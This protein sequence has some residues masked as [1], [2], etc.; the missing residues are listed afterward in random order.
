MKT[1]LITT[2]INIPHVLKLYRACSTDVAFFVTGDMKTDS[3]PFKQF[4]REI[5]NCFAYDAVDQNTSMNWACHE[6]IGWNTIGRRNIA[7]LEA[8]KWGADIIVTID[9]DNIPMNLD[10]F[11]DFE[12][13]LQAPFSG[14]QVEPAVWFNVGA[15]CVPNFVQR[16]FPVEQ[17]SNCYAVKHVVNAKI[18]VASGVALLDPDIGAVE[19]IA[20][21]PNIHGVYELLRAGVAFRPQWKQWTVF[22]SQVT[23]FLR[24]LAPAMLM[25]PQWKRFDDI[26]ASLICQRVMRHRELFV[27]HGQPFVA[28]Q[29][30]EHNLHD[31]LAAEA[32]G[33]RYVQAFAAWLDDL[34]LPEVS[35]ASD[36]RMIY[37]RIQE[38]AWMPAGVSDI[39]TTWVSDCEQVLS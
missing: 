6:R 34:E 16:G 37:A 33:M 31:D 2:T 28:Q 15:L 5:P 20:N 25:V 10:Y 36:V 12:K 29:R 11:D 35:I 8:L 26:F 9:D 7:L 18:G 24:E 39:G 38:L 22:N 19:R 14:C 13:V 17:L 3:I 1:A 23:T 27:H 32:W 21:A 4:C 30:N